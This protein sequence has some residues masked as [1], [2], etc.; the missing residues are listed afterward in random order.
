MQGLYWSVLNPSVL[1]MYWLPLVP[2]DISVG[3]YYWLML[4]VC[5]EDQA[6]Q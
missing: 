4:T 5:A 6:V 1:Y 2:L 3:I